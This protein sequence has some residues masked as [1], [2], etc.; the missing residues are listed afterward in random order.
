M[1]AAYEFFAHFFEPALLAIVATQFDL[2]LPK[3]RK[4]F[5]RALERWKSNVQQ[6]K[7]RNMLHCE[8]IELRKISQSTVWSVDAA[9]LPIYVELLENC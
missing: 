6:I 7:I 5:V 2:M 1:F 9:N 4:D 3:T 8:T